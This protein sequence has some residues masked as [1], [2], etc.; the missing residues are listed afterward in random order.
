MFGEEMS[1]AKEILDHVPPR[2][3][4]L[5]LVGVGG[6][7]ALATLCGI[8]AALVLAGT[9]P[10]VFVSVY[11]FG[12][13]R[14]G[15]ARIVRLYRHLEQQ[16]KLRV[17]RFVHDG[18]TVTCR[19][20]LS[21]SLMSVY[22]PIGRT[23]KFSSK[24][25]GMHAY[26]QHVQQ[27]E[28]NMPLENWLQAEQTKKRWSKKWIFVFITLLVYVPII[29]LTLNQQI[30]SESI[31]RLAAESNNSLTSAK[32]F[33]SNGFIERTKVSESWRRGT[34][35]T[36]SYQPR[37]KAQVA[38]PVALEE[39]SPQS[40]E[41][42]A[43][44]EIK[45]TRSSEPIVI[46]GGHKVRHDILVPVASHY[47]DMEQREIENNNF[48][49]DH[50]E[51]NDL[52]KV[53]EREQN[54]H[55]QQ[56]MLIPSDGAGDVIDAHD[57][58]DA[59][60]EHFPL[61]QDNPKLLSDEV[62]IVPSDSVAFGLESKRS[63]VG[64]VV[65]NSEV[66]AILDTL[67]KEALQ[68]ASSAALTADENFN[69]NVS[70]H[71]P[72]ELVLN[73]REVSIPED[74]SFS[75][76]MDGNESS[77]DQDLPKGSIDNAL[78]HQIGR[79]DNLN[80]QGQED[81]GD[82]SEESDDAKQTTIE[83]TDLNHQS[84]DGDSFPEDV[85]VDERDGSFS[86]DVSTG[87]DES[88]DQVLGIDNSVQDQIGSNEELSAE[89]QAVVDDTSEEFN[90][91]KQ[92]II[93]AVYP[94]HGFIDGDSFQESAEPATP[95]M[96][97]VVSN[98]GR[99][100]EERSSQDCHDCDNTALID[101]PPENAHRERNSSDESI[102]DE[103]PGLV[104]NSFISNSPGDG[105]AD[106]KTN[107]GNP[108]SE[109][110]DLDLTVSD[111]RP[112]EDIHHAPESEFVDK[113][114]VE[115]P[116]DVIISSVPEPHLDIEVITTSNTSP[117]SDTKQTGGAVDIVDDAEVDAS[118]Q[119]EEDSFLETSNIMA[120]YD[121]LVADIDSGCGI[122]TLHVDTDLDTAIDIPVLDES[123]T[124]SDVSFTL[125]DRTTLEEP[126][127][128][129]YENQA[130]RQVPL[131]VPNAPQPPPGPGFALGKTFKARSDLTKSPYL[132][133]GM[134]LV[135]SRSERRSVHLLFDT[136]ETKRRWKTQVADLKSFEAM[137]N[138]TV[139]GAF[140]GVRSGDE[141]LDK[142]SQHI[143][144]K[145]PDSSAGKAEGGDVV[146]SRIDPERTTQN[147]IDL[148]KESLLVAPT[149]ATQDD[150]EAIDHDEDSHDG[151]GLS[152]DTTEARESSIID[153]SQ[154]HIEDADYERVNVAEALGIHLADDDI[155]SGI[156][157]LDAT[158]PDSVLAIGIDNE[159]PVVSDTGL[160][161]EPPAAKDEFP[162]K[163]VNEET[164]ADGS[165][166]IV[167]DE[168]KSPGFTAPARKL[169]FLSRKGDARSDLTTSPYL[170]WRRAIV[171]SRSKQ[172]SVQHIFNM[173]DTQRWLESQAA[174][175]VEADA[176]A[177][178]IV[179]EAFRKVGIKF[180]IES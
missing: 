172:K 154:F 177:H 133:W 29:L 72:N 28:A 55:D 73:M 148:P 163:R 173:W 51:Q 33:K 132:E 34:A 131:G 25:K 27:W 71:E 98:S 180:L 136:W 53:V 23:V 17:L 143:I 22:C 111:D 110:L 141:G 121:T 80:D 41:N 52:A 122:A 1:L 3:K 62:E 168:V 75:E 145:T 44:E 70:V 149:T 138:A 150:S 95:M 142:Y 113:I 9:K 155:V 170:E 50:D 59:I 175:K 112:H 103:G 151:I 96:D 152:K 167:V 135:E 5:S 162:V 57:T 166:D 42:E 61:G 15:D 159:T 20:R 169:G 153:V 107:D 90:D 99:R 116:G 74:T 31:T 171:E 127:V 37:Y 7:A 56:E 137:A 158:V 63:S 30:G 140:K 40:D 178:A 161:E 106:S 156:S 77:F 85:V 91:S 12:A 160:S 125:D 101:E 130:Q 38:N 54:S 18:D 13:P 24:A 129:A 60:L 92:S 64:E 102:F 100:D 94:D 176:T 48:D 10:T 114:I 8:H 179:Q 83:V 68:D 124:I 174:D 36:L 126:A 16:G 76:D 26:W 147:L 39:S 65:I 120:D 139:Q 47:A 104:E 97:T 109:K 87:A 81:V 165:S 43:N 128:K 86:E 14:L 105:A 146:D 6:G 67:Q 49:L 46:V 78:Q 119:V 45:E 21:W 123:E 117:D 89:P 79:N 35:G 164:I 82:T 69:H 144:A 84:I 115:T 134:T 32:I 4:H 2:V 11:S 58:E 108:N 66:D 19:P 118:D 88:L 93:E 157:G